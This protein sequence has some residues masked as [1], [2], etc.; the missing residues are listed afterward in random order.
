MNFLT[1]Q[2]SHFD[3]LRELIN[4]QMRLIP[5]YVTIDDQEVQAN[6]ENP[7]HFVENRFHDMPKG[8]AIVLTGFS[9]NELICASQLTLIEGD[10]ALVYWLF[11]QPG[12]ERELDHFVRHIHDYC[13]AEGCTSIQVTK[14]S[15]GIGWSE[16][17]D[18][19]P[20]LTEAFTTAGHTIGDRWKS[21]WCPDLSM[22]AGIPSPPG[23]SASF[24]YSLN[25]K[26]IEA[27]FYNERGKVGEAILW[28]PSD[29]SRSLKHI[30][31]LEYIEVYKAFR[32]QGYGLAIFNAISSE[33]MRSGYT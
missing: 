8:R 32:R 17:P 26:D 12:F 7:W 15:F 20:H 1:Y 11:C 33:M 30:F 24:A 9:G 21:Y 18:A 13:K 22:L 16:I 27:A 28:L 4:S 31:D 6:L 3:Q 23:F 5:P 14:C 29:L 2:P 10:A 25:G 19:W